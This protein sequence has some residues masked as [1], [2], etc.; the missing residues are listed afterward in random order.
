MDITFKIMWTCILIVWVCLGW[1]KIRTPS[2]VSL[3]EKKVVVA[4]CLSSLAACVVSILFI[5]WQ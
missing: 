1:M 3:I 2:T 5:I 4:I